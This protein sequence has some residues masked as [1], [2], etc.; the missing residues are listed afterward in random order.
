MYTEIMFPEHDIHFIAVN[1]GVDST[2]GDNEFTP[3]RN[4]INEWYAKDTSKKIR[5][6]MKVKGNAGEHL[7]TLP[8]YGYMKSPDNKKLWVR[9]EEAAAVVYEIGLYVMDGFGPSQIARKLTE[10]RI[11]TPA[12]YYAS[13]GRKASNIKRGLPYAWDASTVA[14]IMDRWREYLG[15]TVNFKTRKKSYKSKKV[16]HNP[17]SE[18]MIF[19]N[20]HDPIWTEAIADAA[21][22]ASYTVLSFLTMF[23]Y[24]ELPF[25]GRLCLFGKTN[26]NIRKRRDGMKKIVMLNW[27]DPEQLDSGAV[28]DIVWLIRLP[29][30]VL[31]VLVGMGLSVVGA[32]MQAIVKN[33]LADPYVLGISSGA[34]LGATLTLLL[35]AGLFGAAGVGLGAFIGA[36]AAAFSVIAIAGIGGR[37]TSVKLIL[38]GVALSSLC[39][40]FSNLIV[41]VADDPSRFMTVQFWLMGSLAGAQWSGNFRILCVVLPC[42]LFF[43]SQARILNLMLMGDDTAVTLGTDLQPY[44]RVYLVIA[45]LMVGFVVHVSGVIGFVGLIIPHTVRGIFGVDHKKLLPLSAL[46]GS[47]FLVWADVAART[48]LPRTEVPIGILISVVGAPFFIFLMVRKNYSFGGRA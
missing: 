40:A 12:A 13:R 39:S 8:P 16:I 31:A 19:E 29:R 30:V 5:A 14:D 27:G 1:D 38:A 4:I 36:L 24:R 44:R 17:E 41:Y 7:T 32:V 6:V 21:R 35:G 11:L 37:I 25:V 47:V 9:D 3:F 46:T 20:T 42:T 23:S 15:H 43:I 22:A 2:Q 33:P 18:W 26:G 48:I 34:S 45:S 28:H 10:R